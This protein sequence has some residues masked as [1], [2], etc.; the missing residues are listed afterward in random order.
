MQHDLPMTIQDGPG[1][2]AFYHVC[3][4]APDL[5]AAMA[6]LADAVGC[7]W[8]EPW[9]D[10]LG[11]WAFRTTFSTGSPP[12]IELITGS[13]GSPWDAAP[14]ARF[15][16]LGYWTS[17]LRSGSQRLADLGFPEEFSGCP[18][19]RPYTGHRLDSIGARIELF[20]VAAQH[21]FLD[22]VAPGS[23]PMP[24]LDEH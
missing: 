2:A 11:E 8:H 18:Y 12:Y 10:T 23:Q 24:A 16:H 6:D 14:G 21:F 22:R 15:D 13:A 5:D 4:V 9:D 20:D 19:G 1:G 3:F 7:A 17:S